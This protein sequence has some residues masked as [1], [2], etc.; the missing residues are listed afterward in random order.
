MAPSPLLNDGEDETGINIS[1]SRDT[2][3]FKLR[4]KTRQPMS[5]TLDPASRI[6]S[7][8]I[9]RLRVFG[10][11]GFAITYRDAHKPRPRAKS[12]SS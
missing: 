4:V 11:K 10:Q 8:A 1:V 2:L 7:V 3:A 6:R 9:D 5:T 12:V